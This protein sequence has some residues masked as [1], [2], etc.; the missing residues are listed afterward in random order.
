MPP[1]LTGGVAAASVHA[2]MAQGLSQ[3]ADQARVLLHDL[4]TSPRGDG[5]RPVRA[6]RQALSAANDLLGRPLCSQEEL[7]ARAQRIADAEA[8]LRARTGA[9]AAP[10]TRREAAP[11]VVYVDDQDLRSRKKIEEVLKARDIPYKLNDVT[12]DYASRSWALTTARAS[13]LPL[14]FVAGEPI[15][16]L[17]E[18]TQA[19]VDG[20]LLRRVYGA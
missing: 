3:K 4:L 7:V 18:L 20:T 13:E 17:H 12:E 15:G 5:L 19:D 11:V 2:V 6:L 10:Q 9:G 8:A 14:V 1:A 16:G